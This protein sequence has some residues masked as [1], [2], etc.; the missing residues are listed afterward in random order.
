[1]K[2]KNNKE[3]DHYLIK[4]ITIISF[5]LLFLLGL[6]EAGPVGNFIKYI[7]MIIFGNS[8]LILILTFL[9]CLYKFV[10]KKN[11]NVRFIIGTISF[12]IAVILFVSYFM[13][14]NAI[15][16]NE[17]K[18]YFNNIPVLTKSFFLNETTNFKGGI[19]GALIYSLF[20]FLIS[21]NGVIILNVLLLLIAILLLVDINVYK[22]IINNIKNK[23]ET[24]NKTKKAK[25]TKTNNVE[26]INAN[27][28][29]NVYEY[30]EIKKEKTPKNKPLFITVDNENESD[31]VNKNNDENKMSND[32]SIKVVSTKYNYK[33]YKLPTINLL[34]PKVMGTKSNIN[35]TSAKIKGQ[36]VIEILENFGIKSDLIEVHIGPSVTKFE[37]K[38]DSSVKVSKILNI[39]DNIKME[40]AARDVRIEAPISGRNA[41]GIEIP[42]AESIPVKMIELMKNIP[43]KYKEN[44][45]LLALGKDLMG[46]GVFCELDKMPHLLIAGQTGS[47]K[48]VCMNTIV[49][50]LLI[51]STP[52]EVKL[53]LVDPK[54]VEFTPYHNVPHLLGPVISDANDAS[55]AL[56]VIVNMMEERY[57]LFARCHVRNIKGYNSLDDKDKDVN[58]KKL[59]YIVV[60]IDELA[61][62]MAI[63]GKE[64][65]MSIQ[66]ITQLARASG[67]HLI[68]ATQRPSTDV[69]T[70]IIKSNI[71]S[72][73]S[74]AVASGID[75][76]TILDSIGAERLLGN[77][78]MLYYPTGEPSALR[79]QG[80][81]LSDNE[82]NKI[83]EFVKLQ[84]LPMYDDAFI[85]LQELSETPTLGILNQSDDPLFDEVK[86]FVIDKQKASTSLL[87]RRFGIGYN[88]A[89]RIIDLLEE[90][91]VIGPANGSKPRE[92]YIKES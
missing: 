44:K 8:I 53:L 55:N 15:G 84:G 40:L 10:F 89:A 92:V 73:I 12:N 86:E 42:N 45:L 60:I 2:K 76:R 22:S 52:E 72:R 85:R 25:N 39:Q 58:I 29:C 66:R 33:S 13:Q 19:L 49:T 28:N 6:F 88:R 83:T 4:I 79:L 63:A 59:P 24:Y 78:D 56:K 41:V 74:F 77:G 32:D 34:E 30:E 43:V 71:P 37:I 11:F 16:F 23:K 47:G 7:A 17:T 67:I 18:E 20:S 80:V 57:D 54:K 5:L 68:V 90:R 82:V 64:V 91:R 48:S 26:D 38:P 70:G 46:Q 9:L 61:D 31:I 81:Y 69:I 14:E 87:Q 1:M 21:H 36:K 50:S 62:L 3:K 51:R 65:E 35:E 27:I 75:S